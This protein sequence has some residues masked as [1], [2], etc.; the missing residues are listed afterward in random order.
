MHYNIPHLLTYLLKLA[1]FVYRCVAKGVHRL[2]P[3]YL[4]AT[5]RSWSLTS[6]VLDACVHYRLQAALAVQPTHLYTIGDRRSIKN[7]E[8]STTAGRDVI[9]NF[10]SI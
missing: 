9:T 5:L 10:V 8:Q 7:V 1:V 3:A 2:T 6:L 4:V